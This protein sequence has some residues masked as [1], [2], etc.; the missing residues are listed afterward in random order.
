MR[1]RFRNSFVT[2]AP[3]M[4]AISYAHA[5]GPALASIDARE[6]DIRIG[7]TPTVI[8]K[9]DPAEAV[10]PAQQYEAGT[11]IASGSVTSTSTE[12]QTYAIRFTPGTVTQVDQYGLKA[13]IHARDTG[14]SLPVVLWMDH[15]LHPA[16]DGWVYNQD[17]AVTVNYSVDIPQTFTVFPGRYFLSIDATLYAP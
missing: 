2:V 15:R 4:C 8:V 12:E 16:P 5:S 3:L 14:R 9:L 13:M 17:P 10:R 1:I 7:T 11:N 6:A